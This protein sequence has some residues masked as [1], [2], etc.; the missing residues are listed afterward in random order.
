MSEKN[1]QDERGVN[2]LMLKH[3]MEG[4]V[5]TG[6]MTDLLLKTVQDTTINLATLKTELSILRDNVKSISSIVQEGNGNVS[7]LTKIALV[8]QKLDSIDKYI[9]DHETVHVLNNQDIK[10]IREKVFE[11]EDKFISLEYMVNDISVRLAKQ[12][13]IEED[14]YSEERRQMMDSI[15]KEEDT[16]KKSEKE[17]EKEWQQFYLKVVSTIVLGII[18]ALGG[19]LATH[20]LGQSSD[21]V[22]EKE[23]PQLVAPKE[24]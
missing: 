23:V 9:K 3:L 20:F 2:D 13:Q 15:N 1:S 24:K 8:E 12:E 14:R 4:M 7:I 11:L 6:A 19:W 18:T 21:D 5:N 10:E 17:I 22:P 16:K